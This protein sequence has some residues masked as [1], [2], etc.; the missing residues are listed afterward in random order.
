ME[1][2]EALKELKKNFKIISDQQN[3][4]QDLV[5]FTVTENNGY[6][7]SYVTECLIDVFRHVPDK[8]KA[9]NDLIELLTY[10]DK[11]LI[12]TTSNILAYAFSHVPNTK[13]AWE[14]LHKRVNHK[15]SD[16]R[17]G[18][19]T[20]IDLT[21]AEIPNKREVWDDLI[22]LLNDEEN[23]VRGSAAFTL[24]LVLPHVLDKQK[25]WDDLINL[26]THK[27]QEVQR[28]SAFSL[29][30]IY[31]EVP[32]KK[33][34]WEDIHKL[35]ENESAIVRGN[36]ALALK[37]VLSN[38][39]DKKQAWEDLHRLA[40]DED[41]YIK[42]GVAFALCSI[43]S[44]TPNKQQ[45][46]DDLHKLESEENKHIRL[47]VA[48]SIGYAYSA[49]PDKIQAKNDLIS[50]TNDESREVKMN[51]NYS[52]GKVSIYEASQTENEEDYKRELESAIK[53]FE[54]AAKV[55]TSFNP[56]QF[57]LPFY[58]SFHTIIFKEQNE[59][60]EE[61]KTYL[62]DAKNA[63]EGS[64]NKKMLIE[65]V[66]NLAKALKEVQNAENMDLN[67]M[68]GELN[69]YRKYC[70][71]AA[72]LMRDAEE[73]APFATA[74][75]R[76][77]LPILDRKLKSLLEEIQEKAK[78]ACRESKGTDTEEIAC[79]V[80]R[81]VQKWEIGSQEEMSWNV[82]NLIF[83]LESSIPIVPSNQ[84]IF[85]RIQQIREQKDLA[86][87]YGMVATLVPL[88]P[89]LCMEQKIDSMERK[90][91]DIII[92][93]SESHTDLTISLGAD[94]YGNGM[95]VTKT[96][97]IQKFSDHEKGE[98]EGKIQGNDGIKL[99]SLST[100]LVKKIKDHLF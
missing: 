53:F 91:D 75:M 97:P 10:E 73:A 51:A 49:V 84:H 17:S 56:A 55:S 100:T 86:K 74:T 98:I 28:N 41:K 33:Q 20:F 66:E 15:N 14:D 81:E 4:W 80:S 62:E 59:A 63:I 44:G 50:L 16:V 76:K 83:A 82:E 93:I 42:E 60:N 23:S 5:K 25:S 30:H 22:R 6:V 2:R 3:I 89:K 7:K 35:T 95:K 90:L 19:T 79:A 54:E 1:R 18:I 39:P 11:E 52:L 78:T 77:G 24:F 99:S 94:F 37:F 71:H 31:L 34:A 21:F 70:E 8:Q 45:A 38:C 29:G 58:R 61:L 57:C 64:E 26:M 9:W 12:C 85:D 88:I 32:N 43:N 47:N 87:Q 36:A 27:D 92:Y 65:A 67:A 48:Y 46:W 69:F 96:I 40:K 68:K 13:K 72:E